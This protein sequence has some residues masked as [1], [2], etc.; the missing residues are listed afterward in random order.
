MMGIIAETVAWIGRVRA[1]P[2]SERERQ[3]QKTAAI[4]RPMIESALDVAD[5]MQTKTNEKH[6]AASTP[7][8][9]P[10]R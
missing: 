4:L 1:C 3:R 6:H 10:D 7:I 8:R 9:S 2:V 5:D